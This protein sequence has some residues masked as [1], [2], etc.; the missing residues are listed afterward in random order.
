METASRKTRLGERRQPKQARAKAT[1]EAILNTSAR[2]LRTEGPEALNTNRIAEEVGISI[3]TLYGYF[4]HKQEIAVV[5]AQQLLKDDLEAFNQALAQAGGHTVRALIKALLSRHGT[6]LKLRQAVIAIHLAE[7][8]KG[9]HVEIVDVFFEM[10]RQHPDFRHLAPARLM[11]A[12]Q[13][14]LGVARSL[15]DGAFSTLGLSSTELEDELVAMVEGIL[16]R[17]SLT[18]AG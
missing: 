9:E 15:A 2:I 10:L 11:L 7:G 4:R 3:G 12:V 13:A 5:L 14:A 18:V 1:V 8:H 16:Q 17:Q 6:D